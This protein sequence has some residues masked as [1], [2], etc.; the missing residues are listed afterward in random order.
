MKQFTAFLSIF[1]TVVLLPLQTLAAPTPYKIPS[2]II[3]LRQGASTSPKGLTADF[4]LGASNPTV[5][6]DSSLNLNFN[7][8]SFQ[9]GDATSSNKKFV[10]NLGLGA[11]NPQL[12]YN[13]S[14]SAW[15]FSTDGTNFDE[16]GS[17][18]GGG[19]GI[20]LLKNP[21]FESGIT[22]GWANT[23]GTFA[24]VS[25][26]GNLLIGKGSATFT[27]SASGQ[28]VQSTA[29]NVPNG[30]FG[31]ACAGSI[32][33]KGADTG[34]KLQVVD[35]SANILAQQVLSAQT[36]AT[37]VS[38]PFVCPSSG[39]VR[40]K[41]I[42][43]AASSLVAL[44]QTSLGSNALIALS[45]AYQYGKA[46]FPA[47]TSCDWTTTSSTLAP[48]PADSDC[49]FPTV[50]GRLAASAT[51]TPTVEAPD[52]PA[53]AF[54]VTFLTTTNAVG[55]TNCVYDIVDENGTTGNGTFN[56]INGTAHNTPTNLRRSFTYTT[57]GSHTF[58]IRGSSSDNT[59]GCFLSNDI[60]QS[61]FIVNFFPT[62]SQT[63]VTAA[64]SSLSWSGYQTAS[65]G[66]D[67][68]SASFADFSAGTGVTIAEL[69][70]RNFGSVVS[71]ASGLPAITWNAP[72]VGRYW[73]CAGVNVLVSNVA[74]LGIQLLDGANVIIDAGEY[75]RQTG[76]NVNSTANVCGIQSISS[77]GPATTKLKGA[78]TGG[79]TL[80]VS[81]NNVPAPGAAI[82]WS[83]FNI[84]TPFPT[85][86]LAGS[87]VSPSSGVMNTVAFRFSGDSSDSTV[88]ASDPCTISFQTGGV[89]IV[90]NPASSNYYVHFVPGTFSAT[91]VCTATGLDIVQPSFVTRQAGI[92]NDANTLSLSAW[93]ALGAQLQDGVS[94]ICIGPK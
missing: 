26:G 35:G 88:C 63:A 75:H 28:F 55:G 13:A 77:A 73:V 81:S 25:T 34:L 87:V 21:G 37:T 56:A 36:V 8:N 47:A 78:V 22:V 7:K 71:E 9:L 2:D 54:D 70:N 20:N 31:Q 65:G 52:A 48:F 90:N 74:D 42:S 57:G 91:P 4:S 16:F 40:L 68:T 67:T 29:Y 32:I 76:G 92:G 89:S 23:G 51:L 30:L 15:E 86:V 49:V 10:A 64:N 66:W 33:Y 60:T 58:K 5:S 69:T 38:L 72:R 59:T 94:V 50:T 85:P 18:S 82:R 53:G 39:T 6:I 93:N 43:S 12:R 11:A 24:A 3:Q 41:V 83:I 14:T 79:I 46:L 44:D 62:N 61:E 84:D 45:Q 80:Q 19:A 1:L 27:A 17:G